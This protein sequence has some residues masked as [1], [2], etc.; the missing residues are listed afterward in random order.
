MTNRRS[1][2]M[3]PHI[4]LTTP[5]VTT[6]SD[7]SAA[8]DDILLSAERAASFS[9]YEDVD[10]ENSHFAKDAIVKNDESGPSAYRA[11]VEVV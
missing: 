2:G 3:V 11:R 6:D 1:H 5:I 7:E 9:S 10:C 4:F 8:V